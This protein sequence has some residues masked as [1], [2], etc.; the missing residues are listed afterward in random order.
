MDCKK[1]PTVVTRDGGATY[2]AQESQLLSRMWRYPR[3][4]CWKERG[5]SNANINDLTAHQQFGLAGF[6]LK[7]NQK[8][9]YTLKPLPFPQDALA[10]LVSA[11]TLDFH[12]NKHHAGYVAK[13]N[14][15]ITS[16]DLKS[17]SISEIV[18]KGPANVPAGIYNCAAQTYNHTFYWN[19]LAPV[20]TRQA[21]P[22]EKLLALI[23]KS[24]GSFD[25]F[26]AKFSD[27][28][29]GHFGSGWAW[30]VQDKASGLLKIVDT[31]DAVSV[32]HDS[33]VKPILVCD[34]WEHAYYIDYRNAR[35]K[36]VESWWG[37]VNWKF[38][39]ANATL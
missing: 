16:S 5:I 27:V 20:A 9:S 37:L 35:P 7:N 30:L 33:S 25:A 26:K 36:Y 2:A 21:A 18:A 14:T 32:L 19:S 34:V 4:A 28:A 24:F 1:W 31:H 39:E 22:S 12:Y 3:S 23:T 6:V 29:A 38:A 8:M 13:L 17:L 15:L 10:P 11:E